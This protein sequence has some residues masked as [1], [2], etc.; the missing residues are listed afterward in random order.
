MLAHYNRVIGGLFSIAARVN[1]GFYGVVDTLSMAS[2]AWPAPENAERVHRLE[3]TSGEKVFVVDVNDQGAEP[4]HPCVF[5][6]GRTYR[7]ANALA[8]A[9]SSIQCYFS[10]TAAA[11]GSLGASVDSGF[12]PQFYDLL[13]VELA[14]YLALKDERYS[15]SDRLVAER[16][17]WLQLYVAHLEHQA[18]SRTRLT[19]QRATFDGPSILSLQS[20]LASSGGR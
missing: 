17:S 9:L 1:P 3:T 4:N 18:P 11:A 15:E 8:Q 20:L 7:P 2:G 13:V 6:W 16:D 5:D 12:P 14:I 10:R 19:G